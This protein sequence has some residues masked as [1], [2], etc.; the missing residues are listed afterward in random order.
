MNT[1]ILLLV[2][3][4]IIIT[5]YVIGIAGKWKSRKSISDSDYWLTKPWKW[6]FEAVLLACSGALI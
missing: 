1:T 4:F 3:A 6:L 5:G 2:A